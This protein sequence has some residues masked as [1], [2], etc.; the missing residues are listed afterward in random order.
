[1][2]HALSTG[3]LRMSN[4]FF[5]FC[6]ASCEIFASHY[7][8]R[9]AKHMQPCHGKGS[10]VLCDARFRIA[11]HGKTAYPVVYG[12]ILEVGKETALQ[13]PEADQPAITC[14]Q[15]TATNAT[16]PPLTGFSKF[17]SPFYQ[18]ILIKL[19]ARWLGG[20]LS[21]ESKCRNIKDHDFFPTSTMLADCCNMN[22]QSNWPRPSGNKVCLSSFVTADRPLIFADLFIPF[23]CYWHNKT[24]PVLLQNTT[25]PDCKHKF[26][27]C[28]C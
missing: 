14:L 28:C 8:F 16:P 26:K 19:L 20:F 11:A 25:A 27:Y 1:M 4:A 10:V 6:N 17:P 18:S 7:A 23:K 5:E 2:V 15:T 9:E 13:T 21:W 3:V 12:Q 22:C 24:Q